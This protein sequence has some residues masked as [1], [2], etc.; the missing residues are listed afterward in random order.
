MSH[1]LSSYR[2]SVLHARVYLFFH[3]ISSTLIDLISSPLVDAS[4]V[5]AAVIPPLLRYQQECFTQ[6]PALMRILK[7]WQQLQQQ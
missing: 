3:V 4:S 5:F 7:I 2:F 6:T 1:C